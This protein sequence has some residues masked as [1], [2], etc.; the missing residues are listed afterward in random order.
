MS[1]GIKTREDLITWWQER[2]T[3]LLEGR[4]IKKA[5]Y[6]SEAEAEECEW[7]CRGLVLVLDDDT[8]ITV[9]TDP[10]GNG[11][12]SLR[13]VGNDPQILGPV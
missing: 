8:R 11:P 7:A 13:L 4:T 9:E 1:K 2:A 12:G 6:M 5:F 10:A 3:E